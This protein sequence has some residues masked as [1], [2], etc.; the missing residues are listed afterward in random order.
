MHQLGNAVRLG[1]QQMN[2]VEWRQ[3]T[4]LMLHAEAGGVFA[5]KTQV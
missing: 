4:R 5:V 2:G 1:L 3:Y